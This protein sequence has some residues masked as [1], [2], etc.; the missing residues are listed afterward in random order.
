LKAGAAMTKLALAV[1]VFLV[2]MAPVAA[3]AEVP[4]P[5]QYNLRVGELRSSELR[6]IMAALP[7]L[8]KHRPK[9]ADYSVELNELDHSYS[10][11]FWQPDPAREGR[12]EQ[13]GQ[14]E[15]LTHT[16]DGG[17]GVEVDKATNKILKVEEI[18][19]P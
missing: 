16:R 12:V 13:N 14:V 17:L 5:N 7:A 8:K 6:A 1:F 15:M 2:G 11:I 3:L 18:G 10:V 4:G 19:G 9:W